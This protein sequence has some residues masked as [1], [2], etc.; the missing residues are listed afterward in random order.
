MKPAYLCFSLVADLVLFNSAYNMNSF[1][2]SIPSFLKQIPDNRPD[3]EDI[4]SAIRSK[5]QVLYFAM[6][7][8]KLELYA[9]VT[10]KDILHIVWPHRW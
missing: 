3:A 4:V 6:Q 5:C 10:R 8:P 1:L 2:A 7:Y 9:D